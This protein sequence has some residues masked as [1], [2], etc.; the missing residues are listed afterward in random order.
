VGWVVIL[1]LLAS[2]LAA[3]VNGRKGARTGAGACK[4]DL[5]GVVVGVHGRLQSSHLVL[6]LAYAR[7]A[8][9]DAVCR[10]NP[11]SLIRQP[12]DKILIGAL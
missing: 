12:P 7:G 3:V 4:E 5:E 6:E 9:P 1:V 10:K 2:A 8:V 11:N